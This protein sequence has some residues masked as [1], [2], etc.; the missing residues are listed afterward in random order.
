M[1]NRNKLTF[2]TSAAYYICI[3][4]LSV[5][6]FKL[7]PLFWPFLISLLLAYM[8]KTLAGKF[9]TRTRAATIAAGILFYFFIF[10]IFWLF[11]AVSV[12]YIIDFAKMLPGLPKATISNRII[13]TPEHAKR[14]FLALQDNINKYENQN[15]PIK[16]SS[17]PKGTYPMGFGPNTGEA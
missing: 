14:L 15:G 9:M 10:L 13:M 11:A 5:S 16:L 12:G 1:E 7:I 3:A 4:V 6:A 8:F 17:G 2:L